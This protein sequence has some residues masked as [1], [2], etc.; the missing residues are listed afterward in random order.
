[1]HAQELE[2]RSLTATP[3]AL[4]LQRSEAICARR[5]RR[6]LLSADAP[7]RRSAGAARS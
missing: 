6:L 7:P 5:W 2:Q 4:T 3:S 1:M